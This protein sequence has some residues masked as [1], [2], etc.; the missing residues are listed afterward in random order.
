MLACPF[1]VPMFEWDNPLP[2]LTKCS[3][4]Y[5]RMADGDAPACVVVCPTDVMTFGQFDD[6]LDEDGNIV[7]EGVVLRKAREA[8]KLVCSNG[9][10]WFSKE[11]DPAKQST[12][13]KGDRCPECR[14]PLDSRY[15]QHIYGEKEVGGTLWIYISDKPFGSLGFRTMDCPVRPIPRRPIPDYT[16]LYMIWTPILGFFWAVVLGVLYFI[17][18]RKSAN[19]GELNDAELAEQEVEASDEA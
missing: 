14:E 10:R 6:V 12:L 11:L 7:S 3:F 13:S 18:N 1:S 19:D 5:T 8:T 16:K 15:V 17:F 9:H 4:C 2:M